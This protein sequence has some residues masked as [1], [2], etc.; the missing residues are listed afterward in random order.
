MRLLS[1]LI[2]AVL[3]GA[4][5]PS[6]A[7]D[8]PPAF[9]LPTGASSLRFSGWGGPAL[10]VETYRPDDLPP[11]APIVFVMHGT[12]RN[13]DDYRDA[14]IG[15][16]EACRLAIVSPAFDRD[17]FPR[18][19]GYN[20]GEPLRASG[21]V[22]AFDAI[23]PIFAAI[24]N[25]LGSTRTG[26]ALFGHSAGAQFVHRFL[27]LTPDT[28]VERAVVANAGWYTWPDTGIGWPYGLDGAPRDPL[29]PAAIAALPVTLLLG[30]A[31]TDPRA[32]HLRQTR[33]AR[34]QGTSRFTRGIRTAARIDRMAV[35]AGLKHGWR[36]A[37]VP[38]VGHDNTRMAP[39]AVRH[40]V[41]EAIYNTPACRLVTNGD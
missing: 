31:D 6:S 27:M 11:D 39:A 30:E 23:E 33:E 26:Y 40:L 32:P 28:R 4:A 16:A 15:I 3:A 37:T 2:P 38:D 29:P 34:A 22:S 41:P 25:A 9:D 14:W 10:T 20:L 7:Q 5:G 35:A 13:A 36:V 18:A 21:G 8:A 19:A 1:L 12:N 24:H 17:H